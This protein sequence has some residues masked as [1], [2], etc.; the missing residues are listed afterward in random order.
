MPFE[1][2]PLL[3]D[4]TTSV[5]VWRLE[6]RL[7]D[8]LRQVARHIDPRRLHFSYAVLKGGPIYMKLGDIKGEFR[9][10]G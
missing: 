8:V 4:Y 3:A 7:D 5:R 2:A 1:R 6:G 9:P 10:R